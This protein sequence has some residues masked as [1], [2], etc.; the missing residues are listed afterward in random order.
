M[1]THAATTTTTTTTRVPRPVVRRAGPDDLDGAAVALAG[2]FQDDPVFTWCVP[3]A[4]RRADVLPRFFRLVAGALAVHDDTFVAGVTSHTVGGVVDGAALW[5]PPAADPV[6]AAAAE[7]FESAL[8]ELFGDDAE[9]TF[10]VVGLL[11]ASHPHHEDHHYLW[12]LG[13]TPT[14]QGRGVGSALL[15]PALAVADRGGRPAYLEATSKDNRRLYERHGF[16]VLDEIA[17]PGGPPLWPMW[18]PARQR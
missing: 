13:V 2:A 11:E 17:V 7:E 1:R 16:A 12:F 14:Y 9:R 10:A 5:V 4:D 15:D 8:A 6:P 18:R 3:D